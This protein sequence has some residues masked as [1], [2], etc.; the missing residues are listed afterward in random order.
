MKKVI[1]FFVLSLVAVVFVGTLVFHIIFAF[2]V[3]ILF[4][5]YDFDVRLLHPGFA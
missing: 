1:R 3:V 4:L 2:I 5:L